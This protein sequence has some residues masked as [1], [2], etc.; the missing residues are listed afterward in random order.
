MRS[1]K[2]EAGLQGEEKAASYLLN[3][4]FVMIERNFRTR[5]GEIDIIAKQGSMLIFVEV[6]TSN[7]YS[8]ETLEYSVNYRKR[9]KI[10]TTS[11]YFL[12]KNPEYD[13]YEI[14]YDIIFIC[15]QDRKVIHI[16]NAFE[17]G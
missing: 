2:K 5:K 16:K 6:K 17:E 15:G 11:R 13:E 7:V 10:I 12:M 4:G 8:E 9:N 1:S 3:N 14:R